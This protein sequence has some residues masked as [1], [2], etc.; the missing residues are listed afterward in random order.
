[1]VS[2]RARATVGRDFELDAIREMLAQIEDGAGALFLRGPPGIGKT[3]VWTEGTE[4]A[5]SRGIRVLT[6]RPADADARVAF[7]ALRDL[8]GDA[9]DE[10]LPELPE[11]QRR[12]LAV[13]L[14][15][16]EPQARRPDPAAVS[17]SFVGALRLLERSQ[18]LLVAVDDAQWLDVSSR[19][20]LAFALRRL[21]HIR[22]GL[23]AT[24][25]VEGDVGA[26]DL[27]G[28]LPDALTRRVDLAPLTVAA[29]YEIVRDRFGLSLRRSAL[30]RLH[31]LSSGNPFF[32]LELARGLQQDGELTVP[33]GLSALLRARLAA[34]SEPTQHLL[35]AAAA[36]VRPT[37]AALERISEDLDAE[38][39]EAVAAE[40]IE[41]E[42]DV[43]HFTHPLL[44]SVHY[45]AAT[46]PARRAVHRKLAE[47]GLDAEEQARHLALASAGPDE[48]VARALD[49]AVR[50]ARGRG[51]LPSAA[52]LADLALA[53]TPAG[54]A[55]VHARALAAADL[56]R[57]S[58]DTGRAEVLLAEAHARATNAHEQAEIRLEQGRLAI[59]NDLTAARS[60]LEDALR[61]VGDDDRLRARVLVEIGIAAYALADADSALEWSEEGVRV[62][63]R[64]GDPWVLAYALAMQGQVRYSRSGAIPNEIM[65]RAIALE[66]STGRVSIESGATE[67]YG[68]MHIHAG[69]LDVA[70]E[71]FERLAARARAESDSGLTIALERLADVEYL[72]GHWERAA[73]LAG[74]ALDDA[75]QGGRLVPEV[76]ALFT[77]GQIEAARGDVDRA[78]DLCERSL[79]LAEQCGVWARGPRLVLGFLELSLENYQAA[80]SYL[81][82]SNPQTGSLGT[83]RPVFQVPE[84]V[85][86]LA[87]L[88]RTDEARILLEPFQ[89]RA[90]TLGRTWAVAAAAHGR[91]LI[92]LAEEDLEGAAAEAAAAVAFGDGHRPRLRFG[93]AILTLGTAQRQLWRKSEAAATLR[94]AAAVFEELGAAIWLERARR[95]LRRIGGRSAPAGQQLSATE[96]RIAALVAAGKTNV[97]V[98]QEL[99]LSRKTVEWN[100]SKIYRKRG[101]RSRTEL[102]SRYPAG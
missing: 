83:D 30:L 91:S 90:A 13:A 65:E 94:R 32:A 87:A 96:A 19:T 9:A 45:G 18:P 98:A 82:P 102:A 95:E 47:V 6:T 73:L 22:V 39:A 54:E 41:P 55:A 99:H 38:L 50:T 74:E 92:L 81:D 79:R 70:R 97:E 77:L 31:E 66:E 85:E 40:I 62:A 48:A 37:R 7:A 16:E 34:M 23:L 21:E 8:I 11:P 35:L 46:A 43:I 26:Q 51:A 100:L 75:A 71:T 12:A 42:P 101:V 53:L 28:A 63:E 80:W 59:D 61:N 57:S 86:A 15:L 68:Q 20:V 76:Q 2:E 44:A 64:A 89:Q 52:E 4:L 56:R 58:G 1:M 27:L 3:R 10:V 93:R 78:R 67:T 72:A 29:L 17:A 25:R 84:A 88:G 49:D 5:R 60:L 36:L 24:V 69:E 33:R 14:L